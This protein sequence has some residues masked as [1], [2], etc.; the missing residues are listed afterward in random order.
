MEENKVALMSYMPV[1][2]LVTVGDLTQ[3]VF[4]PKHN[5]SLAWVEEQH[6]DEI[7]AKTVGCCGGKRPAFR[8]ADETNIRRWTQ[9]G[10]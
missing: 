5:I 8:L 2:R 1:Q 4:V 7:L 9:G 10:R 3:Y 6:V